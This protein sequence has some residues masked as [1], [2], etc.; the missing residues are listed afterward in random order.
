M[1]D[2]VNGWL[3]A[4]SSPDKVAEILFDFYTGKISL[5]REPTRPDNDKTSGASLHGEDGSNGADATVNGNGK[6]DGSNG[7]KKVHIGVDDDAL[8]PNATADLFVKNISAPIPLIQPDSSAPSED[9]FTIGNA[10]RWLLL[11]SLISG[12]AID[13]GNHSESKGGKGHEEVELLKSMGL[14][15]KDTVGGKEGM[16]QWGDRNVWDMVMGKDLRE[17]EGRVIWR[18]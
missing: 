2:G 3:V 1:K 17:G 8:D 7:K 15:E 12:K 16:K 13:P 18:D 6:A 5:D 10:T 4:P 11:F 9:F 14:S